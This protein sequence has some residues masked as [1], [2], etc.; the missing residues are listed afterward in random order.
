[1]A[2]AAEVDCMRFPVDCALRSLREDR[3]PSLLLLRGFLLRDCRRSRKGC[4][5]RNGGD[6][7]RIHESSWSLMR[8]NSGGLSMRVTLS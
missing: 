6:K 5:N 4:T 1:M 8:F 2:Y 7:F 3:A